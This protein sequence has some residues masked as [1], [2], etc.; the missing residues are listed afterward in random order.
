MPTVAFYTLG[1]K[2][3]QYDSQAMLEQFLS[4]GYEGRDFHEQADVYVVNS[5]VVT[6]TGEKK[7]LQAVRR[8]IKQNP[9]AQVVLA[10]CLAQKEAEALLPMGLRLVIGNQRRGEV[11]QLL[12]EAVAQDT[13][14]A[15]VDSVLR[16]PFELLDISWAEGHTRAVMKIQEGCDR[17]CAYCIIPYVRGGIR[18][19]PVEE[20]AQEAARLARAGYPEVVL[21]GIHLSSYGR[22]LGGDT[23]MD[24]IRAVATVPG[25]RRIRLGSLEPV[26]ATEAFVNELARIPQ[27]CPQFHLSMQSGSDSVLRRMRR[28]YTADEYLAAARRLQASFPGCAL[29]TDVLCGFPG[30]TEEEAAQ[31]LAFCRE[32]GFARMHVFPFSAREG[33]EAARMSGQLTRAVKNERAQAL[34]ALGEELAQHYRQTLVGTVQ[35]VLF[36]TEEQQ[37]A[38]GLTPQYVETYAPGAH[39][40]QIARVQLDH[41]HGQRLIGRL[42]PE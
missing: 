11:V 16:V 40:G 22:D 17:Y 31:T 36:E 27:L 10:G 37:G 8:A 20:I 14:I 1:C 9:S 18:S 25:V 35:E 38:I 12:E 6:G 4:A 15:A 30:E 28:R 23:L 32:V 29:T 21:T 2:V 13:R 26:V 5:C 42:L 34:I 41:V 3:N 19:R 33:T 7:S 24:A 39:G